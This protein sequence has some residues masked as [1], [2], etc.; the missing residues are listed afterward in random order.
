MLKPFDVSSDA[1]L[2]F[3][4]SVLG[5]LADYDISGRRDDTAHASIRERLRHVWWSNAWRE[6][7][8]NTCVHPQIGV[9]VPLATDGVRVAIWDGSRSWL[10][11]KPNL[12]GPVLPHLQ[13]IADWNWD[14][15]QPKVRILPDWLRAAWDEQHRL[16]NLL[17]AGAI[18]HDRYCELCSEI[19]WTKPKT[20]RQRGVELAMEL[21]NSLTK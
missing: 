21:L 5:P 2:L 4:G 18:P 14:T 10:V 1:E 20:Q 8:A 7:A 9:V 11:S 15:N 3:C 19:V 6:T 16:D 12:L 13:D 17:L